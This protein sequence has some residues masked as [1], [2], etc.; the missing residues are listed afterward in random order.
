MSER[1]FAEDVKQL[2]YGA[3]QILQ[4]RG[5][6]RHHQG[7]APVGRVLR[8]RLPGRAD[9]APARRPGRRQRVAAQ[10]HGHLL[11][12]VGQRGGGGRAPGRVDQLPDARRR[13]LEVGGRHQRRVRRALARGLG[14]RRRRRPHRDRRGLR[15]G[16]LD[17]PGAHALRRAEVAHPAAGS[18]QQPRSRSPAS[19]RRASGSPRRATSRCFFSIRIRAC[20]MRGTLR[21]QGQRP[22]GASACCRRSRAPSFSLERINLP[23]FTYAMEAQEVRPS[24][25]RPPGATSSSTG[26]TSTCRARSRTS[27]IVMQGGLWNTVVRGLHVLGAG[28]PPRRARRSRSWSST[29]STRWCPRS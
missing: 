24:G 18:P 26:S 14:R 5:H 15:R 29:R 16:R 8:R 17:P 23:P 4:R 7:P 21:L 9:L 27:G 10:A 11:R 13:H 20:H 28:R 25:C 22:P 1:S 12:A 19:S 2:G 3:G 6:P